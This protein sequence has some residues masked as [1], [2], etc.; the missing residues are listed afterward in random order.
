MVIR[1][2][3]PGNHTRGVSRG[4]IP[5]DSQETEIVRLTRSSTTPHKKEICFF[6]DEPGSD[7]DKLMR[8]E[9]TCTMEEFKKSI[10][11]QWKRE[12]AC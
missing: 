6:C 11:S 2:R 9:K 1:E 10:M 12:M 7:Q 3:T 4:E 8:S 5:G